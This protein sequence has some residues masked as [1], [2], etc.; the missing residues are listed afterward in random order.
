MLARKEVADDR[1][2]AVCITAPFNFCGVSSREALASLFIGRGKLAK[3]WFGPCCVEIFVQEVEE[4]FKKLFSIL[5]PVY[6][7]FGVEASA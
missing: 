6:A 4:K 5:L 1:F 2:F 3:R 7:P